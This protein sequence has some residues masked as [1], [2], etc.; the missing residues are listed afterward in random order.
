MLQNPKD[1]TRFE[2]LIRMMDS[3]NDGE[4]LTALRAAQRMVHPA[5]L[6]DVMA[7]KQEPPKQESTKSR[8]KPNT[9]CADY[10]DLQEMI[11]ELLNYGE[12]R[13]R[14][15]IRDL[16]AWLVDYGDLTEKQRAALFRIYDAMTRKAERAGWA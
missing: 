1:R 15:F 3:D 10:H 11:D 8:H 16:D 12:E 13:S 14:P 7:G 4:A 2:K 9:R 6:F 5:R